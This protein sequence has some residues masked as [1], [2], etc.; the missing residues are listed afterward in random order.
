MQFV[1]MN[2]SDIPFG[3]KYKSHININCIIQTISH[4]SPC[5]T[6]N[7]WNNGEEGR[8][9]DRIWKIIGETELQRLA[10]TANERRKEKNGKNDN[11]VDEWNERAAKNH[12][13][14]LP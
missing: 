13:F 8:G 3:W 12:K 10:Q 11:D 6:L 2:V 7:E 5:P 9:W 14:S 4:V 1:E